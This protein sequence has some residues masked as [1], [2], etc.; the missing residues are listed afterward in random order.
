[1]ERVEKSLTDDLDVF[2]EAS[3][4]APVPDRL[5]VS[6]IINLPSDFRFALTLA[7]FIR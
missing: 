5:T 1:M 2:S 7:V 4:P 6:H 3:G